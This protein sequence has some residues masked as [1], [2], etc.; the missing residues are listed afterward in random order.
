LLAAIA[1]VLGA[2]L[3]GIML[4]HSRSRP[5]QDERVEVVQTTA[6]LTER[7]TQLPDIR[8]GSPVPR[9]PTV[10]HV[11]AA[12]QYQRVVGA[13]AAITDTSAWLLHDGLTPGTRYTVIQ[14]LFGPR[15]IR[16]NVI[17]VPMGA[18]DF[19]RDGKPYSYDDQPRGASDP[20]LAHFSVA[21]D[22]AY[23]IPLLREIQSTNPSVEILSTPWSPPGWMKTN[24]S[25][26]NPGGAGRLLPSAYAPLAHY[27]VKFLTTYAARGL[28][29][30][31]VAPQNEPGQASLYPG[32]N[33]SVAAQA[34]F[35]SEFLAPA[36][37][38]ARL[39]VG[40]YAYDF[41]WLFWR[42]VKALVSDPGVAGTLAGVAW[43]CYEGNPD[44]MTNLHQLDPGLDEI[45]SECASGAAPGP[46]AELLIASFRNWASTVLLWNVALDPHNGPVQRPNLGCAKCIGVL[47]VDD[48][49]HTVRYGA[50]YYELGQFSEFVQR[51]A[52]R[53][54]SEHFVSYNTPT[55]DHLVNYSSP[56]LDDVAFRNPNGTIVL[57][58]H[59]NGR[60]PTRF[61]V[62]WHH[63]A[64]SYRLPGAATVTFVWR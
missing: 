36:L 47:T 31:A 58:A 46:P 62:V 21:H 10:I 40:I 19:T 12:A 38:A 55:R 53:I 44:A 27:F 15:G 5:K 6:D 28:R 32:L 20:E 7:L 25:L 17:L 30:R 57:I 24:D 9:G 51:G 54:A 26:A 22:D 14:N 37:R 35:V 18:S 45:E 16:L 50:D 56:G 61:T 59:N 23:V 34:T 64:F 48:R 42:R 63:G 3:V 41:K 60:T 8:F 2:G 52:R 33:L 13:G 43:H 1:L 11:D 39:R 4:H 49:D 29:V